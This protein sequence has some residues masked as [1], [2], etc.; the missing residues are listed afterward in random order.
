M[1]DKKFIDTLIA[2]VNEM[3]VHFSLRNKPISH[4]E[5]FSDTGLLPA[6]AK[7]AD[8]LSSLCFGYGIGVVFEELEGTTLGSKVVFDDSTP[9]VLR[10]LCLVDVIY[11]LV[12]S[13]PSKDSVSLDELLYD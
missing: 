6:I 4:V 1:A 13:S 12:K 7:R 3:G 11:E 8:Q 2:V 5:V 10:H 9:S